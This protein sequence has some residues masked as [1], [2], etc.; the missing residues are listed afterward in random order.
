[1][2]DLSESYGSADDMKMIVSSTTSQINPNFSDAIS[3]T[4]D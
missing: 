4:Q 1:M 2:F 3:R